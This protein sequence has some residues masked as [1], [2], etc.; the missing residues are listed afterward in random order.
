[1]PLWRKTLSHSPLQWQKEELNHI[2]SSNFYLGFPKYFDFVIHYKKLLQIS[3]KYNTLAV[4]LVRNSP[5]KADTAQY[6][7]FIWS[8]SLMASCSI[9]VYCAG[10]WRKDTLVGHIYIYTYVQ[11]MEGDCT[12]LCMAVIVSIMSIKN[13]KNGHSHSDLS[14]CLLRRVIHW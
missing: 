1:M 5:D 2:I 12:G 6:S 7:A 11:Y 9:S 8:A 10:D 14:L 4:S 13:N 3:L